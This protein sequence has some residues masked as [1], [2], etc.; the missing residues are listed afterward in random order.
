MARQSIEP[1][2]G[3]ASSLNAP[4]AVSHGRGRPGLR[5]EIQDEDE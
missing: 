1:R 2:A 3:S 4:A 5:D